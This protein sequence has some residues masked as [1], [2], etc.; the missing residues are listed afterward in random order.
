MMKDKKIV[1]V[2][3]TVG[4]TGGIRVV[5]EYARRFQRDGFDVEVVHLL[6]FKAGLKNSAIAILKKIKWRIKGNNNID[7][8]NI[9]D[10]K[11]THRMSIQNIKSDVLIATAYET[12]QPVCDAKTKAEKVYYIQA[13]ENWGGKEADR[14]YTLPMKKLTISSYLKDLFKEKFDQDIVDLVPVGIDLNEFQVKNKTFN[15][16]KVISMLYHTLPTKGVEVGFEAI[17]EAQKKHPKLKLQLF[18]M[19]DLQA[20]LPAN[21]TCSKKPSREALREIYASSDIF[22]MPSLVEGFGLPSLEAMSC[23][24]ALITTKTGGYAD[25]SKNGESAIWVKP[26]N[27]EEL[28]S[29]IIDLVEN[30]EKLKKIALAGQKQAQNFSIDKAYKRFKSVISNH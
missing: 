2:V 27:A 23:G 3:N 22:L 24:C 21:T 9:D 17:R 8:F 30:E 1:F 7:W 25:F 29:A 10:L 5:L 4:M 12:A 16:D 13:Y 14:T 28:S 6:K 20:D 18:G 19:Y 26:G 15:K 11:I